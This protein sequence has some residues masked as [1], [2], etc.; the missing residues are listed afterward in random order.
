MTFTEGKSKAYLC[1]RGEQGS[2]A[3]GTAS[4]IYLKG[5]TSPYVRVSPTSS[6][7]QTH[8]LHM[9]KKWNTKTEIGHLPC[10]CIYTCSVHVVSDTS[11][12]ENSCPQGFVIRI[13]QRPKISKKLGSKVE[14]GTK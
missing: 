5:G 9:E 11:H 14:I 3:A 7:K 8:I 1:S 12:Q 2:I 10:W 6:S 4:H 13:A